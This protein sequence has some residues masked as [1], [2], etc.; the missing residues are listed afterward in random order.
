MEGK[1][2]QLQNALNTIEKKL[3]TSE[4]VKNGEIGMN[5]ALQVTIEKQRIYIQEL[6]RLNDKYINEIAKVKADLKFFLERK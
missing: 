3:E 2:E 6:T 4:S 5:Q 1:I